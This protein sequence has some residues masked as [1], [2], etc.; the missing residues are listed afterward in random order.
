MAD[1]DTVTIL[2][3]PTAPTDPKSV[4]LRHTLA[5]LAYRASKVLRDAPQEFADFRVGTTTRTPLAILAHMGDLMDW[6]LTM[7]Q[8]QVRWREVEPRPWPEEVD[9]FFA[10]LSALDAYL[11]SVDSPEPKVIRRLFQGPVADALTHTGQLALLRRLA[12]K[13][14][15]PENYARAE[16]VEGNTAIEQ[17]P[18]RSEFG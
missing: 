8:G 15:R 1:N 16:I 4:P 6:A 14:V 9:R 17:P 3:S 18:P 10:G 5:T 11:A 2:E 7:A 13:P 12:S